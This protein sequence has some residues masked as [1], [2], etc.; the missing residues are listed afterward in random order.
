MLETRG[1]K[2]RGGLLN[3]LKLVLVIEARSDNIASLLSFQLKTGSY[4]VVNRASQSD[5]SISGHITEYL[6]RA[7][8]T[9][10]PKNDPD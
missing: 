6:H 10:V 7:L 2:E 4:S 1:R 3:S 8:T 9:G 5:S